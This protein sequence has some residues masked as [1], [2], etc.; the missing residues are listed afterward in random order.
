MATKPGFKN[1]TALLKAAEKSG[2]E[3][4]VGVNDVPGGISSGPLTGQELVTVTG[5]LEYGTKNMP[6]RP[7]IQTTFDN[8]S[9]SWSESMV[10]YVNAINRGDN[11]KAKRIMVA[12][13]RG[14]ARDMV[15]TLEAGP[16]APNAPSTVKEK[17]FNQPLVNTEQLVESITTLVTGQDGKTLLVKP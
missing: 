9:E 11:A 15:D 3:M 17:G 7:F 12:T 10:D 16:W 4:S 8:H 1:L 2:F 5:Y 6:A 14:A 13:A